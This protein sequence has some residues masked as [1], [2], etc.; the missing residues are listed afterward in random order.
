MAPD[1]SRQ[2]TVT[3]RVRS[4]DAEKMRTTAEKAGLSFSAWARQ[5]LLESTDG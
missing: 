1:E 4:Q 3:L 2:E 5:V